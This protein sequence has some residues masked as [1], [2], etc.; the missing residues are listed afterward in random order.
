MTDRRPRA[1]LGPDATKPPD[2][3]ARRQSSGFHAGLCA[4]LPQYGGQMIL[5][6]SEKVSPVTDPVKVIFSR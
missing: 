2:P 3:K 6:R 5:M 1:R 4:G